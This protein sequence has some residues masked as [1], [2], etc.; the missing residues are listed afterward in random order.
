MERATIILKPKEDL[1]IRWGHPWIYDNEIAR[2][3]GEPQQATA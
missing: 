1:R 2:V 3:E